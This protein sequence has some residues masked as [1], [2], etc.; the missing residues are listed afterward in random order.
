MFDKFLGRFVVVIYDEGDGVERSFK[1]KLIDATPAFVHV[2]GNRGEV[3]LSAN[4]II[5]I[6][7]SSND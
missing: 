6:K 2:Q 4:K 5:K 1:G 7:V 3:I